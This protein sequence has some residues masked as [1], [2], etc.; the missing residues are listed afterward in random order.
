MRKHLPCHEGDIT[1]RVQTSAQL[2]TSLSV[3]S[4]MPHKKPRAMPHTH[5]PITQKWRQEVFKVCWLANLVE[6]VSFRVRERS[7]LKSINKQKKTKTN[8]W[9]KA[10]EDT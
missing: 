7:C 2:E 8:K 9:R 5:N 4:P 1:T 10:E 3:Q 6:L